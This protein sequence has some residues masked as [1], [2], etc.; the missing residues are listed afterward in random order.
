MSIEAKC[1][2]T[3][4]GIQFQASSISHFVMVVVLALAFYNEDPGRVV[5]AVKIFLFTNLSPLTGLESALLKCIWYTVLCKI[6]GAEGWVRIE[7]AAQGVVKG[8][9]K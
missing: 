7:D 5:Y 6:D 1:H 2:Q 3:V 9:A 4:E 8:V